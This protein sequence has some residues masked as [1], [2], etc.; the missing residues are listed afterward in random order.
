VGALLTF[1]LGGGFFAGVILVWWAKDPDRAEKFAGQIVGIF[2]YAIRGLTKASVAMRVQ[3]AING[4]RKA[5][6]EHGPSL[7]DDKLKIK[8]ANTEEAEALLREG[9]VLV[10]MQPAAHHEENVA[11]A[12][13]SYLP[14]ALVPRGR[15]YADPKRMRAADLITARAIL[16][17]EGISPGALPV[18][19]EDHLD[20]A[21]GESYALRQAIDETDE[22][23]LEGW[24]TRVLLVEY[25]GL[26]DQLYP[27]EPPAGCQEDAEE[28]ARFVHGKAVRQLGDVS[29]S[30]V[31]KSRHFRVA[32]VFV[33]LASVVAE[34]GLDP[35]RKRIARY[36]FRDRLD[37]VYLMAYD[38]N[39][40]AV[41]EVA[42][43]FEGHG[44]VASIDRYTFPLRPDFK[45]R[46][47]RSRER[48]I[49][50]AIRRRPSANEPPVDGTEETE[51]E[52]GAIP[53][54]VIAIKP[55][56]GELEQEPPGGEPGPVAGQ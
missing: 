49:V 56:E 37:T 23:D 31:F 54:E 19:F 45:K 39:I 33:A 17:Q 28:L 48:A 10:V 47:Q 34:Q 43:A 41:N 35:Y 40:D 53:E 20:P 9:E 29:G 26:G 12:L 2:A 36:L 3:G 6:M 27:G 38:R 51:S 30:R 8:W 16:T 46:K 18:F 11:H 52:V 15:R 24:L 13:M 1:L 25:Q 50:V 44:W 22:I 42:D 14:K 4:A 7:L 5:L 55:P 21:R 32:I